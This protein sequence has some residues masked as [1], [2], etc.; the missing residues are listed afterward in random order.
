M[1]SPDCRAFELRI[2]I[3]TVDNNPVRTMQKL[4]DDKILDLI[5]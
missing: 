1:F 2:C 5:L 3:E 4:S